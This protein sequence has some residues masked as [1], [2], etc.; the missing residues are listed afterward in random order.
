MAKKTTRK[1]CSKGTGT[2]KCFIIGKR[3]RRPAELTIKPMTRNTTSKTRI[4]KRL[5]ALHPG[6]RISAKGNVYYEYRRNRSD[7]NK[8]KRL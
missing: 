6:K 1:I 7:K 4:D 8:T 3:I 5:P 2:K